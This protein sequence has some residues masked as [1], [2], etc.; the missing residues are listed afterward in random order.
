MDARPARP[1]HDSTRS[2]REITVRGLVL[3]AVITVV[4]IA[5]NVYMGL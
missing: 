4:F 3:G 5:A 2:F 1:T